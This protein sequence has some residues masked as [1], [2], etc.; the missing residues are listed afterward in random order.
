MT[1]QVTVFSLS[2]EIAV[3][4]EHRVQDWAFI[5]TA[6]VVPGERVYAVMDGYNVAHSWLSEC[7]SNF[8]L[9]TLLLALYQIDV[10]ALQKQLRHC[11]VWIVHQVKIFDY[12]ITMLP[13]NEAAWRNWELKAPKLETYTACLTYQSKFEK[14]GHQREL[15]SKPQQ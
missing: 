8:D 15:N 2:V 13:S 3:A 5:L 7:C 14:L 1:V 9:N 12:C 11:P 10:N 4:T 6:D